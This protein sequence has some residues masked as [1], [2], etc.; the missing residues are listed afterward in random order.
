MLPSALAIQAPDS[1]PHFSNMRTPDF[2]LI[3]ANK[4]GTTSLHDYL[5]QHPNVYMIAPKGND[6]LSRKRYPTL[7]DATEYLEQLKD[8]PTYCKAGEASSIYLHSKGL[9]DNIYALFPRVKIIA[10]LRNPIERAYSAVFFARALSEKDVALIDDWMLRSHEILRVGLY[11]EQV[12]GYVSTFPPDSVKIMLFDD[13][14]NDTTL[15]VRKIYEFI[16][17]DSTFVPETHRRHHVGTWYVGNSYRAVL[18]FGEKRSPG[19]RTVRSWIPSRV[20]TWIRHGLIARSTNPIPPMPQQLKA[21]LRDYYR[22]DIAKLQH[23]L[24]IDCSNWLD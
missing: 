22:E 18:R 7:A 10:I 9:A 2:I 3:G 16:G 11:Y 1:N 20:R 8:A 13:L 4:A 15:F 17:V 12:K 5:Q 21:R 14:M 19:I 6:L 24:D 23:L